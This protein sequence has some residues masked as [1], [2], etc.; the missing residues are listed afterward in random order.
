[1][2]LKKLSINIYIYNIIMPYIT[3]D[4]AIKY[5]YDNP[6]IQ[7]IQIPDSYSIP[8]AKNW[9]KNNGYL[10]RN[11]RKTKNFTRFIQNDVILGAEYFSKT[12]PNGIIITYQKY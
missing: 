1:M 8:E 10:F 12:L 6:N 3:K 9:L 7:T 11:Y 4:R 5:G 2:K